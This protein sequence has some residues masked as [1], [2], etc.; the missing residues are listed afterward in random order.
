MSAVRMTLMNFLVALRIKTLLTSM[1]L[2]TVPVLD[3]NGARSMAE[4][5]EM[6][7]KFMK[8]SKMKTA[9]RVMLLTVRFSF[10]MWFGLFYRGFCC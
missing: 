5:P 1:T 8:T 7:L 2:R 9:S 4:I 3:T 10:L 6:I